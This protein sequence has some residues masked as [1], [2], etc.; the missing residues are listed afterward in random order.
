M[1][2]D[3]MKKGSIEM[4]TLFL[5]CEEDAYGYQLVQK[6]KERSKG[7]IT[8][9]EGSFYPLLYRL[10]D[11]GYIT[12]EEVVT[13]MSTGRSRM[14]VIYHIENAG[15]E[16]LASLK[17]DYETVQLGIH[18]ILDSLFAYKFS[19]K[20]HRKAAALFNKEQLLFCG[21][22][23]LRNLP[24]NGGVGFGNVGARRLLVYT[25]K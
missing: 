14:R 20:S 1:A 3:T 18:N 9:Q 24:H 17:K 15:R 13:R 16:R 8:V 23:P 11:D 22:R 7:F 25:G 12:G 21:E 19:L 5:L 6:I 4:L 2:I 10:A